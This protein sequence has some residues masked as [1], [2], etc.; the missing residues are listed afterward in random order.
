MREIV[1][2]IVRL[3]DLVT[4]IKIMKFFSAMLV[5]CENLCLRKFHTIHYALLVAV[6]YQV[7][8]PG[9]LQRYPWRHMNR[10]QVVCSQESYLV[11]I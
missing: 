8:L 3:R 4:K 2:G 1:G 11:V 9:S 5:L 10:L 6:G 7:Y